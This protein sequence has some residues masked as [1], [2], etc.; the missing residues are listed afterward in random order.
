MTELVHRRAFVSID[1]V[2]QP[3]SDNLTVEKLLGDKDIICLSDLSHQIYCVGEHFEE[4]NKILSNFQLSAPTKKYE[5]NIL[6][7]YDEVE[8]GGFLADKM[9]DFLEK[10]L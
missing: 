10:I 2:R 6:K 3:L 8:K 5:K 9:E 7:I 1:G 4:A